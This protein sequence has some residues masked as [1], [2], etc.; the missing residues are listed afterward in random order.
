MSRMRHK[1]PGVGQVGVGTHDSF[2]SL[3]GTTPRL[4]DL[5]SEPDQSFSP[6]D[7]LNSCIPHQ[8]IEQPVGDF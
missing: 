7:G 2:Q 4:L 6:S 5:S 8:M 1:Y 3:P